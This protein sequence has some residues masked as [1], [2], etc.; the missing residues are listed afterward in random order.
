MRAHV[1]NS[2]VELLQTVRDGLLSVHGTNGLTQLVPGL[3]TIVLRKV[4]FDCMQRR[5]EVK[6]HNVVKLWPPQQIS[7]KDLVNSVYSFKQVQSCSH[8]YDIIIYL[9]FPP[10]MVKIIL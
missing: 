2:L 1:F 3:L 8:N 4:W 9:T 5:E 6:I 7:S 10:D